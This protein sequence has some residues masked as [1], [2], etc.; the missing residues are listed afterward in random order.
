I[1]WFPDVVT[2]MLPAWVVRVG[3]VVHFY[4]AIL[5]VSAIIIWHFFFVILLPREYPMSWIWITGRQPKED[6]DAHHGL[7]KE[8][9][10]V[11][12]E[13]DKDVGEDTGARPQ[14]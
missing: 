12:F 3:E 4:E 10:G 8:L 7:A 5:A 6:W 11:E 1:L 2:H 13:E 14:S 9:D